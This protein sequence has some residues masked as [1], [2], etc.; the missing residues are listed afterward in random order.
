MVIKNN[1]NYIYL[2]YYYSRSLNMKFSTR[3]R[4]STNIIQMIVY[5]YT[6]SRKRAFVFLFFSNKKI[7]QNV[8]YLI[9]ILKENFYRVDGA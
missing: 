1:T 8:H 4:N 2:F 9:P 5:K 6:G 3:L 7:Y